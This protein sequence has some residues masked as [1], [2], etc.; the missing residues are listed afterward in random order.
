[1]LRH[2][3]SSLLSFITSRV[4]FFCTSHTDVLPGYSEHCS[5]ASALNM[6]QDYQH[7]AHHTACSEW[8]GFIDLIWCDCSIVTWRNGK[9]YYSV[10]RL[11]WFL[12]WKCFEKLPNTSS[13]TSVKYATRCEQNLL[14]RAK[15]GGDLTPTVIESQPGINE[16][17]AAGTYFTKEDQPMKLK[18]FLTP[19]CLLSKEQKL[20]VLLLASEPVFLN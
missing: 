10:T 12:A 14:G 19:P 1:M 16:T 5:N 7:M 6:S 17:H 9:H 11:W 4:F 18:G 13:H 3:K 15:S 2:T 8:G 20:R